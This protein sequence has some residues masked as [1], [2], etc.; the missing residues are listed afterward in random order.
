VEKVDKRI[1]KEK[2]AEI[3]RFAPEERI[4]KGE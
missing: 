1:L 3:W 4:N 2:D